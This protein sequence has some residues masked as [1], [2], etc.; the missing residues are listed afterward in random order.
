MAKKDKLSGL[1]DKNNFDFWLSSTGYLFPRNETELDVF[2]KLYENFEHK[3]DLSRIDT[4]KI[5]EGNFSFKGKVV[6]L[7]KKDE[8]DNFDDFK[9]VARKGENEIPKEIL[10]KMRSKHKNGSK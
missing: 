3:I 8:I 7:L 1:V 2:E 4:N 6:S 10:Q 9:M 5:I